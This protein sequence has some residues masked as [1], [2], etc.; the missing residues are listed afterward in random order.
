MEATTAVKSLGAGI[1]ALAGEVVG[2]E[3]AMTSFWRANDRCSVRHDFVAERGRRT[4]RLDASRFFSSRCDGASFRPLFGRPIQRVPA[5]IGAR[6]PA[7]LGS[8]I[9]ATVVAGEDVVVAAADDVH[10][11][12]VNVSNDRVSMQVLGAAVHIDAIEMGIALPTIMEPAPISIVT[13]TPEAVEVMVVHEP[14]RAPEAAEA[15]TPPTTPRI[16]V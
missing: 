4:R 15:K 12:S 3:S 1:P 9:H 13:R 5:M 14:C 7:V 16:E 10:V 8:A 2:F 6:V 11:R